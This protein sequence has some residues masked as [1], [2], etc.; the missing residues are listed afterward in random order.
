VCDLV[1]NKDLKAMIKNWYMKWKVRQLKTLDPAG[2]VQLSLPRD[3]FIVALEDIFNK[4]NAEMRST[5]KSPIRACFEKVGMDVFNDDLR[6]FNEW[7]EKL[8]EQ[9]YY[10]T[11][12]EAHV[13]SA[14]GVDFDEC[15]GEEDDLELLASLV[16]Q[17]LNRDGWVP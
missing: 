3:E 4:Y 2:V 5:S 9:S 8:Q 1:V 14:E 17:N 12:T 10:K 16:E 6:A 15:D 11:L 13:E 7:M